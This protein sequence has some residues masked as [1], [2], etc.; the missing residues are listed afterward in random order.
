MRLLLLSLVSGTLVLALACPGMAQPPAAA[1]Q[2]G[3]Y[4]LLGLGEAPG[5]S[6][7]ASLAPGVAVD[8]GPIDSHQTRQAGLQNL[9]QAPDDD[10]KK[11]IDL[12]Q[13]QIEV[14]ENQ[15]KLLADQVKKAPAGGAALEQLQTQAATLD[16]RSV[17][18]ARRDVELAGA[19]DDLREHQDA[20]ERYG[21][22]LPAQ[23]KELFL[24]SGN[25]E[26]QLSIYG[27]L[28]FGYSKILGDPTR[29]ANGAGRPSTPA[30]ARRCAGRPARAHSR[31]ARRTQG[32]R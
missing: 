23:M 20:E 29:A 21:L 16:A 8:L 19:V 22:D 6:A 10:Q 14:L 24:P 13:K 31:T 4:A 15:M 28:A 3:T 25:N 18:A 7:L 11:K 9:D 12:L 1:P 27:A 5:G 26:T 32:S 2:A 17:Q 30:A